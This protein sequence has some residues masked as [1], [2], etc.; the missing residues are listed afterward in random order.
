[1][2]KSVLYPSLALGL[3]ALTAGLRLW[4]RSA[5]YDDSGL[6]VPLAV[7]SVVLALFLLLSAG[8]LLFLALGRPKALQEQS[9]ALPR[10]ARAAG[11]FA[12]AGALLLAGGALNLLTFFQGYLNYSQTLFVSRR[13]QQE[14]LRLFLSN[15]LV[16]GLVAL[17]SVPAAAALLLRA[18]RANTA[19]AETP[20]PFA[21]L[22]PS[23]FCWLWLIKD[24]RQHTSNP[25]VWDYVLL[26]L[27]I[28]ALLISACERAG[29]TFGVGKPRR[30]VFSSLA[31]LLLALAALPDA[32]GAANVLSLLALTLSTAAELPPLL[33][34]LDSAPGQTAGNGAEI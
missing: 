5:G 11:L 17:A 21:S 29:F 4:Q 32:G 16:T 22:T 24:F 9:S 34:A 23:V 33:A 19:Q 26:L 15:D 13:E 6:P 28:M 10:G 14:A 31:A 7:P 30:T 12:A 25:I 2:Q 20:G 18:K 1:M 8:A 3:G 27:A